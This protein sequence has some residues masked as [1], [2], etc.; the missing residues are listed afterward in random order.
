MPAEEV[1]RKEN[2]QILRMPIDASDVVNYAKAL[3]GKGMSLSTITSYVSAI[4]TMHTAAGLYKPAGDTKVKDFLVELRQKH[5]GD[6]LRPAR[7]LS[8]S[9][10][11]KILT[12]LYIPRITRGGRMETPEIANRRASVD[13]ALLLTMVQAGMRLNEAAD[14][15]W[16][17]VREKPDDSGQVLLRTNWEGQREVWVAITKDCLQALRSIKSYGAGERSRVFSLSVSQIPKRLKRMCDEAGIES[18]DVSGHTPRATLMR[19]ME[20]ERAP[21]DILLQRVCLGL[22]TTPAANKGLQ[23][24]VNK[25]EQCD[26]LIRVETG[27][28]YRQRTIDSYKAG[29]SC[30]CCL[31]RYAVRPAHRPREAMIA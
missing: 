12:S 14:L 24:L 6:A 13:R 26:R 21:V 29:I 30:D 11:E 17:D 22:G 23:V 10:I 4:G 27:T 16:E 5:A 25:Q 9:E 19:L 8:A 3:D 31:R 7:S 28:V 1:E 15:V 2:R 18:T 20:E